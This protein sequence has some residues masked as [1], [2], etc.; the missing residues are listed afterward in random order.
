MIEQQEARPKE[1]CERQRYRSKD[2]KRC[3]IS[4]LAL[5]F[6]KLKVERCCSVPRVADLPAIAPSSFLAML[7]TKFP[8]TCADEDLG[9]DA[10]GQDRNRA[11]VQYCSF[12]IR[13]EINPAISRSSVSPERKLALPCHT[14]DPCNP[15]WFK[16]LKTIFAVIRARAPR[17][18]TTSDQSITPTTHN[19]GPATTCLS[20]GEPLITAPAIPSPTNTSPTSKG[21]AK[22]YEKPQHKSAPTG[23]LQRSCQGQGMNAR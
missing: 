9:D 8:D 15:L 18:H 2:A 19:I 4:Y 13:E 12:S 17:N 14:P 22:R 7:W 10:L 11:W 20:A 23:S 3:C 6:N 21:G 1:G 16:L 5:G